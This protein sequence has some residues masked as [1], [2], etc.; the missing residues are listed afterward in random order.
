MDPR[1]LWP[2]RFG[3]SRKKEAAALRARWS[4]LWGL[5]AKLVRIVCGAELRGS[6]IF[7]GVHEIGEGG[8]QLKW[9]RKHRALRWAT[10]FGRKAHVGRRLPEGSVSSRR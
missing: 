1:W 2:G 6:L 4:V 9:K 10:R 7:V 3:P 5:K 8:R